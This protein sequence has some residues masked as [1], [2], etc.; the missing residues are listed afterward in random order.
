MNTRIEK[1]V[2]L[3]KAHDLAGVALNPGQSLIYLSGLHFHLMERPTVLIITREG[4]TAVILPELEKGKLTGDAAEFQAFTY[5]DDPASWHTAFEQASAALKLETGRV[6]VEPEH[7]RFLELHYLNSAFRGVDFI[8]GSEV[9][10]ALRLNKDADEIARM[11]QAV[12]IA[13]EALL[14]TLWTLHTGITEKAAANELIVQLL[15]A[16]SDPDLPFE[17]I[18]AFGENSANPHAVPTHRALK[19]GDLILVD[20]G[21]S[22]EGYLSDITRTFTFGEVD[23]ELLRIGEIVR[24]ANQAGREAGAPGLAAGVVDRAAREVIEAAGYGPAFF[25]RTGHGLGMEPHEAPYIY[26]ENDLTLTPGMTFT[27]EPGIY[28]PGKGGVRIEDDVVVTGDGLQSLTD[29]PREVLAVESFI[30]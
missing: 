2:E 10:G 16:G 20:W 18:V 9:L 26:A 3:I 12:I 11:R 15:R 8:N 5:G 24:Q 6:G 19:P 14:A 27:V 13:Q 28:L 17:P 29:L 21:A 25:H 1:C 23:G 22:F 4:E 30:R 7:L